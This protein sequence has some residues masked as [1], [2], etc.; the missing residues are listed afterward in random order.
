[1][2]AQIASSAKQ[3]SANSMLR[4]FKA[5]IWILTFVTACAGT[6]AIWQWFSSDE[7]TIISQAL[8]NQRTYRVFNPDADGAVFYALD[9]QS[10][11][12]GLIPAIIFS[13]KALASGEDLPKIVAIDAGTTRDADLRPLSGTPTNWR[14][15]IAG[16]SDQFDGF[17][18]NELSLAVEGEGGRPSSRYLLGHSLAGLYALDLATR[19]PDYFDGVF[20]FAPT[21]SHDTSIAERLDKACHD[22]LL[23]YANWGLESARDTAVFEDT[24]RRWREAERCQSNPPKTIRHYGAIHQIVMVT[25]QLDA[26]FRFV[27]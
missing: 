2:P 6:V 7:R 15:V 24:T 3:A 5:A 26:A 1:M 19:K 16:R 11:R 23:V 12:G 13:A 4:I 10:I 22:G 27:D 25:G 20:A 8:D 21:F 17:L 14:P 18:L 9:G